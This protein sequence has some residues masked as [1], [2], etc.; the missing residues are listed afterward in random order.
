MLYQRW[1]KS[2]YQFAYNNLPFSNF[3]KRLRFC[4]E[5]KVIS[6]VLLKQGH[7]Q[8]KIPKQIQS[9]IEKSGTYLFTNRKTRS[10]KLFV[11]NLTEWNDQINWFKLQLSFLCLVSGYFIKVTNCTSV[12]AHFRPE[13]GKFFPG[14][15]WLHLEFYKVL[16]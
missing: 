8:L 2:P 10:F 14:L 15:G 12:A 6:F 13:S 9:D 11:R 16:P 5:F 7:E 4:A 1:L 3:Q